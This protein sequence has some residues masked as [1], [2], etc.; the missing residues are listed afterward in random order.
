MRASSKEAS[1]SSTSTSLVRGLPRGRDVANAD[2]NCEASIKPRSRIW[3]AACASS[4]RET[5]TIAVEVR[6][7]EGCWTRFEPIVQAVSCECTSDESGRMWRSQRYLSDGHG[8]GGTTSGRNGTSKSRNSVKPLGRTS[9]VRKQCALEAGL[10]QG[11]HIDGNLVVKKVP[12]VHDCIPD[13]NEFCKLRTL[14]F[15]LGT[16]QSSP[17]MM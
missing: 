11:L 3:D 16:S 13:I 12:L 8:C 10:G 17:T 15:I 1:S 6:Q 14:K 4:A 5:R 7:L 9:D 2:T